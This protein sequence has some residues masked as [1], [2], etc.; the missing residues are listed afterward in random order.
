MG[1]IPPEASS[2]ASSRKW[3]PFTSRRNFPKPRRGTGSPMAQMSHEQNCATLGDTFE[4]L[5]LSTISLRNDHFKC[6]FRREHE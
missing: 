4:I 3:H 2:V 6:V 5:V 1:G